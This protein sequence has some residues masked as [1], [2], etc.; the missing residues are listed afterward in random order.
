MTV[1][2]A[3]EFVGLTDALVEGFHDSSAPAEE[4]AAR[5]LC[6]TPLAVVN[7]PPTYTV[8][9]FAVTVFVLPFRL[10]GEGGDQRARRGGEG[11]DAVVRDAV[12]R[13]EV[14]NHV[15]RRA[16]G[17]RGD[18]EPL[19]IERV[20]ERREEDAGGDVVGE[21]VASG[22]RAGA[23][24]RNAGRPGLGEAAGDVDGVTDRHLRPGDAVDLHGGQRVSGDGGGQ[25]A[26]RRRVGARADA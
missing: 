13:G 18:R 1:A 10:P 5:C 12:N 20:V 14:A 21:Q 15:D 2:V 3:V 22:H 6:E 11:G 19:G 26:D 9:L 7:E 23:T 24:E 16:V 8:E 17:R 25:A 4:N